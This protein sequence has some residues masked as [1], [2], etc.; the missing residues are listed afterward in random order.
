M[1][2]YNAGDAAPPAPKAVWA[3]QWGAIVIDDTSGDVGVSSSKSSK[4]DAVRAATH[5]CEARGAS[6]CSVALTYYNQCAAL[7]W[8]DGARGTANNPSET[9]AKADALKSCK[10][11]ASGCKVVYSACSAP[12][13]VQ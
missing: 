4:S 3:D 13:R 7:A 8:G 5:D 2:G 12:I 11:G 1:P 9:E 6:R 10:E